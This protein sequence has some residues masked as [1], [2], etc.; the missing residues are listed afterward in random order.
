M[1]NILKAFGRDLYP[2]NLN[3]ILKDSY[4]H[5]GLESSCRPSLL[6]NKLEWDDYLMNSISR[7][8]KRN[9]IA[10]GLILDHTRIEKKD[11]ADDNWC[12]PDNKPK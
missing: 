4:N 7:Q 12:S 1:E 10:D 6:K 11:Y 5:F 8:I 3:R 2:S 9:K